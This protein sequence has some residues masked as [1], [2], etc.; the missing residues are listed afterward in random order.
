MGDGPIPS[1]LSIILMEIKII[2]DTG[3]NM[4]RVNR[5]LYAFFK[6]ESL[7]ALLHPLGITG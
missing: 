6:Q 7:S 5:P 4:L 3:K 1:I 2:V